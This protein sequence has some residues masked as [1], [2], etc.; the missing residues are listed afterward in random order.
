MDIWSLESYRR[1]TLTETQRAK[2]LPA[3]VDEYNTPPVDPILYN[4]SADFKSG[5]VTGYL[6]EEFWELEHDDPHKAPRELR[7]AHVKAEIERLCADHDVTIFEA[8]SAVRLS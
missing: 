2:L 7:I 4:R 6:K 8:I 3:M 5:I 1:E